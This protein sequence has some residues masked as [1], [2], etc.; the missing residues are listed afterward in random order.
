MV[1][2]MM[3]A[4]MKV[5][6]KISIETNIPSIIITWGQEAEQISIRVA[7]IKQLHPIT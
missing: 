5:R 1:A 3:E 6:D 7:I 4:D 2:D